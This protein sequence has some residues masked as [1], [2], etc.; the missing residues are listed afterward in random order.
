MPIESDNESTYNVWERPRVTWTSVDEWHAKRLENIKK[1]H[2]SSHKLSTR[3][4]NISGFNYEQLLNEYMALIE[5][6]EKHHKRYP[7]LMMPV[8]YGRHLTRY[9]TWKDKQREPQKESYADRMRR[10][11]FDLEV[12]PSGSD[13]TFT[14]PWLLPPVLNTEIER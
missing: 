3:H 2:I 5:S 13:T 7:S 4:P 8:G 11:V 6:L 1:V 10:L 9:N 14:T 12:S